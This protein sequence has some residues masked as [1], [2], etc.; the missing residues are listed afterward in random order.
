M[1]IMRSMWEKVTNDWWKMHNEDSDLY[2]SA[3]IIR[4]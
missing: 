3:N 2:S 4:V 1:K